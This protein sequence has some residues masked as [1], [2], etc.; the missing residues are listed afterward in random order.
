MSFKEIQ[1]AYGQGF[2]SCEV[3]DEQF[4]ILEHPQSS[5]LPLTDVEIG[6]AFDS[7]VGP[8]LDEIPESQRLRPDRG[9]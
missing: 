5:R 1:L 4:Q 3:D 6:N 9:L 8:A 2:Q 7:P